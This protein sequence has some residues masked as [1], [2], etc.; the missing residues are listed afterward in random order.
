[1]MVPVYFVGGFRLFCWWFPFILLLIFGLLLL[2][3]L[4]FLLVVFDADV[5]GFGTFVGGFRSVLVVLFPVD[6]CDAAFSGHNPGR[7]TIRVGHCS[8]RA[9][10]R[11]ACKDKVK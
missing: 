7:V 11:S 3:V 10:T 1:M 6:F 8:G 9:R 4:V 5:G 2:V